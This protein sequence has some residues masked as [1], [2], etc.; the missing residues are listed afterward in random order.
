MPESALAIQ[1]Y[2]DR[3]CVDQAAGG[4]SAGGTS[5]RLQP[6]GY[7]HAHTHAPTHTYTRTRTH[8]THTHARAR[9]HIR[10]HTRTRTRTRTRTHTHSH[11]H[12]RAPTDSL[13]ACLLARPAG[14]NNNWAGHAMRIKERGAHSNHRAATCARCT[15]PKS[16]YGAHGTNNPPRSSY[17]QGNCPTISLPHITCS[18]P[19][20]IHRTGRHAPKANHTW[21]K[22][23]PTTQHELVGVS[24]KLHTY[25][26]A[27]K[28]MK[29]RASAKRQR[30][31]RQRCVRQCL[32]GHIHTNK[33][34]L[35]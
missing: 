22:S 25:T 7:G 6:K 21:T 12:T 8:T 11:T 35:T 3:I 5:K 29:Q 30:C 16:D 23:P 9:A 20:A 27:N 17:P 26:H 10:K 32:R 2:H 4:S 19:Q 33:I 24:A 34:I 15:R 14:D 28:D 13:P 18:T 1:R 31:V